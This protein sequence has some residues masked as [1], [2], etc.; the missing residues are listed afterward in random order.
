[1]WRLLACSA[2]GNL[3]HA[4]D[5]DR[6]YHFETNPGAY[7]NREDHLT[8][9]CRSHTMNSVV[10]ES[11]TNSGW[12]SNLLDPSQSST[13]PSGVRILRSPHKGEQTTMPLS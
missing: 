8:L 1:M 6:T 9:N 13:M 11:M 10:G 12:K 7:A 4:A 2:Q 5:G 3:R